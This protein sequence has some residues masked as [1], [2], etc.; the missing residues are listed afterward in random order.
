MINRSALLIVILTLSGC[1]LCPYYPI[2]PTVKLEP[3]KVSDIEI[4]PTPFTGS[5]TSAAP[6]SSG[7]Y[8]GSWNA[9]GSGT[10]TG[11]WNYTG[12]N[13]QDLPPPPTNKRVR[14]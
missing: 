5:G 10:Y 4:M 8:S 2:S 12:T 7:T 3:P 1:S 9:A 11:Q 6:N 13:L 14:T